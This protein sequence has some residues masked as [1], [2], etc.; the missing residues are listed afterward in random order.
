MLSSSRVRLPRNLG[1]AVMCLVIAAG[2]SRSPDVDTAMAF[3]P[4][5]WSNAETGVVL[6][7]NA[8]GSGT[9]SHIP[10]VPVG[11]SL[12]CPIDGELD[13]YSGAIGW[14]QT[15]RADDPAVK[16]YP[17]I[18]VY[19][20]DTSGRES[21]QFFPWRWPP[22]DWSRIEMWPCG[23]PDSTRPAVLDRNE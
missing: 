20:L 15:P 8:D 9:A 4:G 3:S 12:Y 18:R 7:L 21:V 16:L 5:T 19:L 23:D 6:T 1:I 10:Y 11:E 13:T 2:C 14:I 17:N 22:E